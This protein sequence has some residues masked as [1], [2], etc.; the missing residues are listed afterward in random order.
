[1]CKRCYLQATRPPAIF[2]DDLWR[3]MLEWRLNYSTQGVLLNGAVRSEKC[4][5]Q[6]SMHVLGALA[7]S[8]QLPQMVCTLC[9]P[10]SRHRL[11]GAIK[12]HRTARL[13]SK[14]KLERW[15]DG[16]GGEGVGGG[17]PSHRCLCGPKRLFNS[18]VKQSSVH[19][20]QTDTCG[21][22][23]ASVTQELFPRC[24]CFSL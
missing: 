7:S 20:L 1:M 19:T 16:G 15:T 4:Q 23:Q 3:F 12:S 8:Q 13:I 24:Q 18:S 9:R 10:G 22:R 11:R 6:D 21:C 14:G 17:R 5:C 2:V